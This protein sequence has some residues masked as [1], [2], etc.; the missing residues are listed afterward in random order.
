MKHIKLQSPLNNQGDRGRPNPNDFISQLPDEVLC[1]ILSLLSLKDALVTHSLS[2]RWRFL[3]CCRN[4][5]DFDGSQVFEKVANN[6][7]M[8]VSERVK[9]ITQVNNIIL[10]HNY[11]I[12]QDFRVCF[13]LDRNN[14]QEIDIWI[15][16]ALNKK[17]EKLELN[18]MTA[19]SAK[20]HD[21]AKN[22]N[23]RLPLSDGNKLLHFKRPSLNDIG[24]EMLSLKKLDLLYVNVSEPTLNEILKYSPHLESLYLYH[25]CLYSHISVGGPGCN[26]KHITLIGF[27]DI[28]SISLFD[29][30]LESFTY[31]GQEIKLHFTGLPKL[32]HLDISQFSV[33]LED[34]VFH[35]IAPCV[36]YLNVLFLDIHI[37]QEGLNVNAIPK[38]PNLNKLYLIIGAEED[39]SLLEFTSIAEACPRLETLVFSLVWMSPVKRRRKVRRVAAHPHP[40]LK[41][42]EILGY[43]GRVSDLELAMYVIENAD[44]L[45]KIVIDPVCDAIGEDLDFT[46]DDFLKRQLEARSHA[47]RQL[48]PKLPR[49]VELVI[50]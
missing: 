27:E 42:F 23:L 10:H 37:P 16:F 6:K 5:L 9:F 13:D 17:V 28:E 14:F 4:K 35:Q 11:P 18:L 3:W 8:L 20:D 25:G 41:L 24:I 46:E 15:Q 21:P 39:D 7:N 49:G 1:I 31:S 30:D 43:Y 19:S 12:V 50:L 40:H 2:T 48:T 22:Y 26:L 45:K 32:K 44:A 34:N 29:F 36:S 38:L 47:K 33:G